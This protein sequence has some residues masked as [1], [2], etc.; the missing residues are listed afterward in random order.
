MKTLKD[1]EKEHQNDASQVFDY[2]RQ[3]AIEWIK[4]FER[5]LENKQ[6]VVFKLIMTKEFSDNPMLQYMIS[7]HRPLEEKA[8]KAFT[9][10]KETVEWIKYFFNITENDIENLKEREPIE[11]RPP[12]K[13]EGLRQIAKMAEKQEGEYVTSSGVPLKKQINIYRIKYFMKK[14]NITKEDLEEIEPIVAK[15]AGPERGWAY[16]YAPCELK[17]EKAIK[18]IRK[19]MINF[20]IT[21]EDLKI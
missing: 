9:L 16:G 14:W 8:T 2:L 15:P 4:E 6:V 18:K 20:D 7:Q 13:R 17:R 1:L 3:S 5:A 11:I 10:N 12:I 21:E 19:Q